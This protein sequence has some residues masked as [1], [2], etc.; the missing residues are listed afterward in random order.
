MPIC[1][2]L[3]PI[4]AFQS[5]NPPPL[6]KA[7]RAKPLVSPPNNSSPDREPPSPAAPYRGCGW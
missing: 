4:L 1:L 2:S 5:F 3:T 6:C 7:R